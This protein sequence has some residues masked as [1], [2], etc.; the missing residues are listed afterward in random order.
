MATT[1]TEVGAHK[2]TTDQTQ[3]NPNYPTLGVQFKEIHFKIPD[4]TRTQASSQFP[5]VEQAC[6]TSPP[7]FWESTATLGSTSSRQME[8]TSAPSTQTL[9]PRA[10][11]SPMRAALALVGSMMVGFLLCIIVC[12][13]DSKIVFFRLSACEVT[14]TQSCCSSPGETAMVV[15]SWCTDDTP[16]VKT[17]EYMSQFN[18]YRVGPW[19]HVTRPPRYLLNQA[20]VDSFISFQLFVRLV[21]ASHFQNSAFC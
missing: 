5:L 21:Q 7:A 14:W 10:W 20:S 15:Y 19:T 18:G 11:T 1:A 6:T 12:S 2:N 3:K 4:L 17:S 8:Q 16:I 9:T 13:V